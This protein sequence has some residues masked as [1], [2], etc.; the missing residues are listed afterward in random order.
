[1]SEGDYLITAEEKALLTQVCESYQDVVLVINTGGLVD[2][3]FTDEFSNIRSILQFM[4][5]GQE[6]GNAFADVISGDVTPSG[7]MTDTWALT[8]G[9]Y[10]NASFFS[11]NSGDVYKEEYKEGIYVGYR[12]YDTS[13]VR[14]L[15][16]F[17]FGLYYTEFS[18]SNLVVDENGVTVTVANTG[19]Y[20]GA[21]VV[22]MY[23]GLENA[24]VFRPK[25]ELKGFKKVFLKAGEKKTI[26]IP[27]DDKTFSYWNVA[28][29]QWEIEGGAYQIM[30][31]ASV[32]DIR[33]E[34]TL[35]V[36][37]TTTECP[38]IKEQMPH[39]YSGIVQDV[40]DPEFEKLLGHAIPDGKWSGELTVNDAICQMY[41]AKSPLARFVYNRLVSIKKKSEAKGKPDLNILFIF[42]MPFRAV[43]KM[44]EGMVS[45]EMVEGMVT[46]VNGHFFKGLGKVIGG[47]FRNRRQNKAYEKLLSGGKK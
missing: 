42:N 31:G 29:N 10:P 21:E 46:I 22:Q 18:Y 28:T 35:T 5:A 14:V 34:G 32:S 38:Y 36:E 8:Y 11:H 1:M 23:V 43:A 40:S 2:L 12:Y 4:H 9:D 19:S 47:F 33:L 17:G 16:P 30:V 20:D 45:M 27:F 7:K 39:Y 26:R 37:G 15:Y 13:T 41:Y 3:G 6:G 24:K 44:T 25:K